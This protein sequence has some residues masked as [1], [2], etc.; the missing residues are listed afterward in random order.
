MKARKFATI[1][2]G[3]LKGDKP[4]EAVHHIS[5]YVRAQEHVWWYQSFGITEMSNILLERQNVT[6]LF[7]NYAVQYATDPHWAKWHDLDNRVDLC[8]AMDSIARG[9]KE[10]QP[11][12]VWTDTPKLVKNLAKLTPRSDYEKKIHSYTKLVKT[13]DPEKTL[14]S[15]APCVFTPELQQAEIQAQHLHRIAV[16][17]NRNWLLHDLYGVKDQ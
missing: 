6:E 8:F 15:P 7:S 12:T 9:L 10:I 2:C 4:N 11:V 13:L 17:P 3:I 1:N 14:Y 5:V 16:R